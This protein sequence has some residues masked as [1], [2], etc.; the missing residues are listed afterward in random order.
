MYIFILRLKL[1]ECTLSRLLHGCLPQKS[2]NRHETLIWVEIFEQQSFTKKAVASKR[3]KFKL[4]GHLR[5]TVQTPFLL[6]HTNS[7]VTPFVIINI[8]KSNCNWI[9]IFSQ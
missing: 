6:K 8:F 9:T 7:D 2:I 3:H 5:D 4:D 1:T